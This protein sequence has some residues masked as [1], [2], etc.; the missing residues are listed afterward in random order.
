MIE[1]VLKYKLVELAGKYPIVTL[2]GPRQSGK[3]TLLR[4]TFPDYEYVSLENNDVRLFAQTD[5]KGF[6]SS[7]PDKTIIDEAQ[8]VPELFSYI[9]TQVDI[10]EKEGVYIL[11]GST[12]TVGFSLLTA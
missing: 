12:S 7:Y 4:A 10:Q 8:R 6:L 2:T 9:Q 3:S 5:P 1:R 11:A